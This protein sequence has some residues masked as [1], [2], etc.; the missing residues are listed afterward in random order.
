[1]TNYSTSRILK[2]RKTKDIQGDGYQLAKYFV[3][4]GLPISQE[5]FVKFYEKCPKKK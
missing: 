2:F 5:A 3:E 4:A 1:M